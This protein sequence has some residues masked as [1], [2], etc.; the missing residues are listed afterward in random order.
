LITG[1]KVRTGKNFS[2]FLVPPPKIR[3]VSPA[4]TAI[5]KDFGDASFPYVSKA[6]PVVNL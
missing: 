5:A 6:Y 1:A 2:T 3:N 4:L